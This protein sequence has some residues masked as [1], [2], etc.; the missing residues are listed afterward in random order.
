M[1]PLIRLTRHYIARI[2][3]HISIRLGQLAVRALPP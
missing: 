1:S 2:L 3:L